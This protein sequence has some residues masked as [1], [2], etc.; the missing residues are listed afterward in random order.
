MGGACTTSRKE[1]LYAAIIDP[2]EDD[3]EQDDEKGE[4]DDHKIRRD[5]TSPKLA[6]PSSMFTDFFADSGKNSLGML[7]SESASPKS[8]ASEEEEIYSDD[9]E[10]CD[11]PVPEESQVSILRL[12]PRHVPVLS[13]PPGS[14]HY[15]RRRNRNLPSNVRVARRSARRNTRTIQKA[16]HSLFFNC[17]S[18]SLA[19]H[20]NVNI[21]PQMSDLID[22]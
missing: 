18:N 12:A 17:A 13:T 16:L 6:Q 3:M 8:E 20:V 10:T 7:E 1:A 5:G 9:W 4:D 22:T 11:S 15:R 19:F 21:R 14:I 2:D